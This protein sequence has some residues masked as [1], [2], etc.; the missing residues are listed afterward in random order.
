MVKEKASH[1]ERVTDDFT[2]VGCAVEHI[3]LRFQY[4]FPN[5]Q[6]KDVGDAPDPGNR[7]GSDK[8]VAF[9]VHR[10]S[11]TSRHSLLRRKASS[12]SAVVLVKIELSAWA[13]GTKALY[14]FYSP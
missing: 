9:H 13:Q 10:F 4:V 5:L 7:K 8:D 12:S 2:D 6:G 1:D 14:K 3:A 11:M